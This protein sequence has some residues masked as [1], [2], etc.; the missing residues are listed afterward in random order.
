MEFGSSSR[1]PPCPRRFF[2]VTGL[3]EPWR[4]ILMVDKIISREMVMPNRCVMCMSA[5]ES[6][7]H[8]L[9]Q[10]PVANSL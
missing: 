7:N 1:N 2:F 4:K 5:E 10:C 6:T 9:V 3:L 8:L